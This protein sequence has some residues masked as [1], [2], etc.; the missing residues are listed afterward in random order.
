MSFISV[1][2]TDGRPIALFA[3]YSLHYVGIGT[4]EQ[5]ISA[6]YL[7]VFTDRLQELLVADRQDIPFV[8]IMSN[9]T[10]D[11][12]NNLVVVGPRR[13]YQPYERVREVADDMALDVLRVYYNIQ[14]HDWVSLQAAREELT[15]Q[16]RKPD[17]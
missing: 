5:H 11:D 13:I 2:S 17:R 14:H 16:V 8:R 12:V 10:S 9:G 15:L 1:Q 3:N 7:L 6:G 4:R